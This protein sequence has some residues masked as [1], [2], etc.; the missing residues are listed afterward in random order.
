M[1]CLHNMTDA[2]SLGEQVIN[3]KKLLKFF[4]EPSQYLHIFG[5]ISFRN[6]SGKGDRFI[7]LKQNNRQLP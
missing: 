3:W 5:N 1:S 7:H 6:M 4:R 2:A